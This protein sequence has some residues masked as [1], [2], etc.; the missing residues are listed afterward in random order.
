MEL[1]RI[2]NRKKYDYAHWYR[3][4]Q[5]R[6]SAVYPEQLKTSRYPDTV[7]KT[8]ILKYRVTSLLK[9]RQDKGVKSL[10]LKQYILMVDERN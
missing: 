8:D 9:S 10:N 4:S 1:L 3:E 6:N 7:T 5:L 2:K